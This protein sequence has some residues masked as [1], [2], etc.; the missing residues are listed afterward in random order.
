MADDNIVSFED[1]KNKKSEVQVG[2]PQPPP[3]PP[4]TPEDYNVTFD[5]SDPLFHISI[6]GMKEISMYIT[7]I[8]EYMDEETKL[9]LFRYI[10][11]HLI[12]AYKEWEL[13]KGEMLDGYR[14]E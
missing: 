14:P 12:T 4:E 10:D 8:V 1:A 5:E 7:E 13:F 2:I 9:E 3:Q 6:N 11:A